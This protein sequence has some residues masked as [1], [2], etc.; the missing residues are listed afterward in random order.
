MPPSTNST[1]STT[2]APQ[3]DGPC[4][5]ADA[6]TTINGTEAICMRNSA[7]SLSWQVQTNADQP[8]QEVKLNGS[9]TTPDQHANIAGQEV[10][11]QK[12]AQGVYAWL[13]AGQNKQQQPT[14]HDWRCL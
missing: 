12:D 1:Q 7:G 5:S 14:C 3:K 8:N 9:C 11:C 2:S 6:R 13:P 10:Q 4:D